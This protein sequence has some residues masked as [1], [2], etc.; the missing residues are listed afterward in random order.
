MSG[1][2]GPDPTQPWQPTEGEGQQSGED[3]TQHV[4]PWQQ[5]SGDQGWQATGGEHQTWQAPAYTPAEYGQYQQPPTPYYPPSQS[6]PQG[7]PQQ[8]QYAGQTPAYPQ[9]PG[10]YGQPQPGQPQPVRYGH[11]RGDGHAGPRG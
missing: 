6:Y 2:Q 4:S 7:Y 1:P 5:S 11:P 8:D 10:Q 3:H 9:Q